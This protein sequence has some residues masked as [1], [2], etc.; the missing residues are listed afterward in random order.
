VTL[1]NPT[2]SGYNRWFLWPFLIW[3]IVGGIIWVSADRR[4]VFEIVNRHHTSVADGLL[5]AYTNLGDGMAIGFILL[6]LFGA[7]AFRNLW[8]AVT[9]VACNVLPALMVQVIKLIVAAPRPLRYWEQDSAWIHMADGWRKLEG[10]H[11]FPSGHTAGAFSLFC[12]LSLL[13]PKRFAPL[14]VVLF[15]L[16]LMVG[17]SR[18]YLAAHFYA[19]VYVGSIV[20][21]LTTLGVYALMHRLQP[22]FYGRNEKA[23]TLDD[24]HDEGD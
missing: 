16:A 3:V 19:D 14:G 1:H 2:P 5:N 13:L 6:T 11:S 12:F 17:Y 24:D 21:T 18:M 4:E 9:A 15:F 23:T 10:H 7:P 20:G 22:R 8:F